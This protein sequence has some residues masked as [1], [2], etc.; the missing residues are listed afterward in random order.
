MTAK[1]TTDA[2]LPL[3]AAN[4]EA[5]RTPKGKGDDGLRSG[6]RPQ[7]IRSGTGGNNTYGATDQQTYHSQD[8]VPAGGRTS[9]AHI[10]TGD[11]GNGSLVDEPSQSFGPLGHA[12]VGIIMALILLGIGYAVGRFS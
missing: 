1:G 5:A 7:F 3:D 4:K 2:Q 8:V 6:V 10:R 12:I 9:T 11:K